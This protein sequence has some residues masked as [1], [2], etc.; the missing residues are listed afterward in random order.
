MHAFM[1]YYTSAHTHCV[2]RVRMRAE[3]SVILRMR[4]KRAYTYIYKVYNVCNV[5]ICRIIALLPRCAPTARSVYIFTSARNATRFLICSC[6]LA[7]ACLQ[8]RA[9]RLSARTHHCQYSIKAGENTDRSASRV[10]I[11]QRTRLIGANQPII[12]ALHSKHT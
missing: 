6:A 8:P 1:Q 11:A 10:P 4:V 2:L 9:K 5:N 12:A 7:F 3:M